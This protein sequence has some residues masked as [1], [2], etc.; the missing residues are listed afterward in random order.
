MQGTT[1]AGWRTLPGDGECV[2][3]LLLALACSRLAGALAVG[4]RAAQI[5]GRQ[6]Q[7]VDAKLAQ[8]QAKIAGQRRRESAL[9]GQIGGLT[10][11]IHALERRVGDVSS[12]LAASGRP[13]SPSTSAGWRS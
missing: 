8:V 6:K 7:I 4:G 13:T 3:A 10:T 12:R 5:P 11:Q 9:S 2:L 1:P